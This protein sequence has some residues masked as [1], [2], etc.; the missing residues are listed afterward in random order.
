MNGW[1]RFYTWVILLCT[2]LSVC[3]TPVSAKED[4]VRPKYHQ[5]YD[6]VPNFY[7]TDYAHIR[8][9]KGNMATSGCGITCLAMVASYLTDSF[10]D[11][12]ELGVFYYWKGNT[13]G[14]R[15]QRAAKDIGLSFR[16]KTKSFE[17]VVQALRDGHPVI[18]LLYGKSEFNTEFGHF[19]VLTGVTEE[20]RIL[21]NDPYEP[22]Y[23]DKN[24]MD[25][26]ANGFKEEQ[27]RKGFIG[28]WIFESKRDRNA[29]DKVLIQKGCM[30]ILLLPC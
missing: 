29:T 23:S 21:V 27:I 25:G 9:G 4:R 10:Y 11:P 14:A 1:K 19:L 2:L 17:E 3:A 7:Q 18:Y 24:L 5:V 28:A 16:P 15:M 22:N 13:P 20:G 30:Q 12:G 26:F 8:Y 6:K